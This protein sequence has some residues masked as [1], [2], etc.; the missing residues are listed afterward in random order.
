MDILL[1]DDECDVLEGLVDAIDFEALG[2]DTVRLA[3]NA[4]QA[5]ELLSAQPVDIM[6]TDIEMPGESGLALMAWARERQLPVVMLFC[7]AFADFNYAQKA[8]EMHAFDYFLKPILYPALEQ[9]LQAAVEE[10][11]RLRSLESHKAQSESWLR[12]QA[13][14]RRRFWQSLT[15]EKG[16]GSI[17]ASW[18]D[19]GIGYTQDHRFTLGLLALVNQEEESPP[20]WKR[21][22]FQ[23]LAGEL[24]QSPALELQA[25]FPFCPGGW[26]A[27]LL[28]TRPQGEQAA[29]QGFSRLADCASTYCKETLTGY[30]EK[31]LPVTEGEEAFRRLLTVFQDDVLRPGGWLERAQYRKKELTYV[32]PPHMA[33]WELLLA[34][35]KGTTLTKE[36]CYYLRQLGSKGAWNLPTLQALRIDLMQLIHTTL[37]QKELSARDLFANE[38]F[39]LLRAQATFSIPCME[40]YVA[41]IM[42]VASDCITFAQQS[43]SVIG[44][45]KEYIHSHLQEELSRTTLAKLAY[46]NPDYFARLFKK[47]TGQ[48]VGTYLQDCRMQRAQKLLVQTVTPVNEVAQQ[49]GYDNFSY[50]SHIFHEKTGMTPNEYRKCKT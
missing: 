4:A 36:I 45:V 3:S 1:V 10:A 42:E 48:S 32:P 17:P 46:L 24:L 39:D 50:F 26:V 44:Q 16:Q 2:I 30:Y 35:G 27:V 19:P 5:K 18:E 41:Y 38:R 37:Q 28:E 34:S 22:A 31:N 7:T 40:R 6:V 15:Q 49:V 43:Q 14:N 25:L 13:E 29:A 23:N 9:R 33:Q 21:Y 12:N 47:E 20:A 11:K 8:I